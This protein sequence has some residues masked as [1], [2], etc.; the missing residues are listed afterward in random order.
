MTSEI[1]YEKLWPLDSSCFI[2]G[3][4]RVEDDISN[5]VD[6]TVKRF[7]TLDI[8]I[9]NAGLSGAPCPYIRNNSLSEFNTVFD[10]NV[11]G[12]FLGMKHAARV[13]IPAK[14]GSIVSLC[15][16]G[17]VVGGIGPH[18]YVGSKHAVVDMTRSIA[19]ELGQHG[20]RVNCV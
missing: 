9:N 10:V 18:A 12:A 19:A 17:G 2:H 16:V 1:N 14:K 11:K 3:D 5:A 7:G 6:F 15:S 8:L 20:I 13:M 4:V